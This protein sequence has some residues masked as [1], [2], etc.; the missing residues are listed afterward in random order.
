MNRRGEDSCSMA[1]G[2]RK[3][4]GNNNEDGDLD[5][6]IYTL[7]DGQR[8]GLAYLPTRKLPKGTF[9]VHNRV[10]PTNRSDGTASAHGCKGVMLSI[11]SRHPTWSNATV[12]SVA[13]RTPP[14]TGTIE[15]G[16]DAAL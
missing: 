13:T 4:E 14:R 10:V 16:D 11:G 8:H 2:T 6:S 3:R 9:L 7:K 15:C 1:S 12:I 5:M